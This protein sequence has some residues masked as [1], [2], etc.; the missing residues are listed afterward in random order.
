MK[1][2]REG[3][4][5]VLELGGRK[6]NSMSREWLEAL[7]GALDELGDAAAVVLIG[8]D[9]FFSAGLALPTLLPL[10]PPE[11]VRFIDLFNATMLKVFELPRP[12]VA[13]V[14]GH[15]IAGGCVLALQ[16]DYRVMTSEPVKIGLNEVALGIG[17]P[18]GVVETLRYRVPAASLLPLALDGRLCDPSE[19]LALGLVNE[20]VPAADLRARAVAR[21][22]ELGRQPGEAFASIKA[23]LARPVL[24]AIR[25]AGED[26]HRWVDVFFTEAAQARVRAAVARFTKS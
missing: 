18:V 9:R 8:F 6:A 1:I 5:A 19:A 24:A 11:L 10:S 7:A 4:V 16:A 25:A 3:E 20:V 12:V 17:L 22:R 26:S 13:A 2:V 23:A 14:N 21:A 15:A